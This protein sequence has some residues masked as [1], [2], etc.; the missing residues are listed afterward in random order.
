VSG[1]KLRQLLPESLHGRFLCAMRD[2]VLSMEDRE[3][4]LMTNLYSGY[5]YLLDNSSRIRWVGSGWPE[6]DEVTNMWNAVR[7]VS[8]EVNVSKTNC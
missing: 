8:R 3:R 5:V 6:G 1:P 4:L 2:A 7:G